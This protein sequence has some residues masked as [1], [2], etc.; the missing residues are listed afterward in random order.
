MS[1]YRVICR[2]I[3]LP[4][5]VNAVTVVDGDETYNV[6]INAHLSIEDQRKAYLHECRHIKKQ[7]FFKL[8][9]AVDLCEKEAREN[10]RRSHRSQ[11]N[12]L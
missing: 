3:E 1:D 9:E 7:H 5:T 6:Y 4:H 10:V 11:R 12:Q 2:I 8:E